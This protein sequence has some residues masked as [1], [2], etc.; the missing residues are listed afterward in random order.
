MAQNAK[1]TPKKFK[2]KNGILTELKV[3]V[4]IGVL[5]GIV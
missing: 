1:L 5:L 3:L 4:L 2:S